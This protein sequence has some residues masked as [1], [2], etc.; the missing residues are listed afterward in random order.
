MWPHTTYITYSVPLCTCLHLVLTFVLRFPQDYF[1]IVKE[2][3][4]LGTIDRKL[5]NGQYSDPWEVCLCVSESVCVHA[6]VYVYAC[7]IV[8]T[9]VCAN[10]LWLFRSVL[11][12]LLADDRQ[13]MAVQSQDVKGVQNVQ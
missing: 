8:L 2:P 5:S 12:G 9:A 4:D 6:C 10:W 3:M 7:V 11:Q 1:A 13:C